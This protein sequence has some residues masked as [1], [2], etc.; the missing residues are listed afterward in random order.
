MSNAIVMEGAFIDV[1]LLFLFLSHGVDTLN[2]PLSLKSLA[3]T[4]L[5]AQQHR[6][7]ALS[8]RSLVE[9]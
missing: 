9:G 8:S 2:I 1:G 5:R 3:E 7:H 4:R 6:R